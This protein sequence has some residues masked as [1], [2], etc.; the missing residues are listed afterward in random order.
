MVSARKVRVGE[1]LVEEGII[2]KE[3]LDGILA[4]Q[5]GTGRFLGEMLV[6]QGLVSNAEL[7][8]V[9]GR[10][11]GV[12]SCEVRPGMVDPPLLKLIG[13]EE[14]MRLK[15]LPM[16]K[17]RDTLTYPTVADIV[18][19]LTTYTDANSDS[20]ATKDSTHIYG[21]YIRKIP[22]LPVGAKKGQ[23]GIAAAT[24]ST[25]GWIYTAS[26]GDIKANTTDSEVDVTGTAWN[27]Y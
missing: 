8:S 6:E 18:A 21:P 4:E 12:R 17:V 20:Q 23:T 2:T 26:T 14:A 22:K 13:E 7:V 10:R 24:G 3:E 19:Q 16:F 27:T 1:A 11:L 9:L 25:V 5:K 15:A